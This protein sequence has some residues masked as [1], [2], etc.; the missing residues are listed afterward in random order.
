MHQILS[1]D[2]Q[3]RADRSGY[4]DKEPS[5]LC[6]FYSPFG[7]PTLIGTSGEEMLRF[8]VSHS[9]GLALYAVTRGRMVG[10]D[11]ERIRRDFT[12]EQIAKRFFSPLEN[13]MLCALPKGHVREKA[14]FSCW[15]RKEA[16]IKAKG[17][18]LSLPLDKFDVSLSPGEPV[19]LLNNS[20]N[21][22][23]VSRWSLLEILSAPGYVAALAVEGHGLNVTYWEL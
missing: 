23:E 22:Q 13:A 16:Y 5:N 12:C 9:D 2:E 3:T 17:E 15:T 11:L 19:K 4:L 1:A 8:N 20:L 10:I 21:P 7:K 18:G 6:F 14:F